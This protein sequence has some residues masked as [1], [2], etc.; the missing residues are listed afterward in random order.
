MNKVYL[1]KFGS[2]RNEI[3]LEN[4]QDST[5]LYMGF[6]KPNNNFTIQHPSGFTAVPRSGY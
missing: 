6:N 3:K 2:D 4:N 1:H 5:K